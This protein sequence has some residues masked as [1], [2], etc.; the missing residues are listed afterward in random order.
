MCCRSGEI[1]HRYETAHVVWLSANSQ[2]QYRVENAVK[3]VLWFAGKKML[4]GKH[5]LM[6]RLI[7][8]VKVARPPWIKS[9]QNGFETEVPLSIGILMTTKS[10]A[11][12]II[13]TPCIR[14]P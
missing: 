13:L 12:Q 8:Y 5:R 1:E 14:V 9:R 11:L 7:F 3:L 10:V 4:G 6:R 2:K